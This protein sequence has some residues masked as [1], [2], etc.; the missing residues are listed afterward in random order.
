MTR[1]VRDIAHARAGDKG[2]T[3]NVC[4][5]AYRAEDYGILKAVLS[6]ERVKAAYA[7]LICGEVTRYEMEHLHG[8]NLVMQDALEGGVNSSLNLDAHGKSWSFL[9]LAMP[10]PAAGEYSEIVADSP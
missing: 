9:I 6:P 4:V 3:S 5:W 7:Q 1:I 8:L 10:L 2:D